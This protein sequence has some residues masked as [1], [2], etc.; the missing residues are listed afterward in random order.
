MTIQ[1]ISDL[2]QIAIP[3]LINV[4]YN[5]AEEAYETAY[6][7]F[8]EFDEVDAFA[9][10]I[11]TPRQ[12]MI[13]YNKRYAVN[14]FAYHLTHGRLFYLKDLP[15]MEYKYMNDWEEYDFKYRI[16]KQKEK[17]EKMW[18]DYTQ[19]DIIASLLAFDIDPQK[20]WFALLWIMHYINDKVS[21]TSKPYESPTMQIRRFCEAIKSENEAF[22]FHKN[23]Y[24]YLNGGPPSF[25]LNLETHRHRIAIDNPYVMQIMY[26][27][28]MNHID[29]ALKT[30]E[31]KENISEMTKQEIIELLD[32]FFTTETKSTDGEWTYK[33][34]E[35]KEKINPKERIYLFHKYMKIYLKDKI[36]IL[37]KNISDFIK[38]SNDQIQK[39]SIDKDWLISRLLCVI[40][41]GE[42][43]Q[44]YD[45]Y[46][47]DYIKTTLHNNNLKKSEQRQ[48]VLYETFSN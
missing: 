39:V 48:S 45:Y 47:K 44:Y 34:N 10:M 12:D 46:H 18:N 7:D 26:N 5:K 16:P 40:G 36:G 35:K 3:S 25:K 2:H 23:F 19:P 4:S 11:L 37:N 28:L 22:D 20:F 21:D 14:I 38:D 31:S 30:L 29:E 15:I 27:L 9:K 13:K 43:K 6:D 8:K 32:N 41:F 42:K 17:L 33:C 1:S 24:N